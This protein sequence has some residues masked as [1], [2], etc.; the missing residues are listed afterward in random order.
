MHRQPHSGTNIGAL[1]KSSLS[2]PKPLFWCW[3]T[4]AACTRR[5]DVREAG[6]ALVIGPV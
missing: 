6:I 4:S 2:W 1:Q 5:S 3:P